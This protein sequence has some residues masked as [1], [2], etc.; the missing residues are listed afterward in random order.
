MLP[1][2]LFTAVSSADVVKL[3]KKLPDKQCT[4]EPL[5][6][7]LLKQSVEVLA[8]FLCRL[9]NW[10][11]QSGI[12]LST[13]KFGYITPL[14]KKADLDPADAKSYRPISNGFPTKGHG[15]KGHWTKGHRQKA[16]GQKATERNVN[17]ELMEGS[18]C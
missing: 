8:A 12:V 5:P 14:L 11:L 13:F 4:S 15:T 1:F 6:T 18:V 2:R 7:W 10:S 17:I 3:V 9:F 16:T